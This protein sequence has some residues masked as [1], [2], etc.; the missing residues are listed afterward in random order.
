[1]MWCR[2]LSGAGTQELK[3]KW[4]TSSVEKTGSVV[5]SLIFLVYSA[6]S[7]ILHGPDWAKLGPASRQRHRTKPES[8]KSMMHL[9]KIKTGDYIAAGF[10]PPPALI[11]ARSHGQLNYGTV[12]PASICV[13]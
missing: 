7:V 11:S 10:L 5:N 6:W 8:F 1:M 12:E 9:T 3:G 2:K 13:Q 4:S